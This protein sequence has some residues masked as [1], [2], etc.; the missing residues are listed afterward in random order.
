LI[1]FCDEWDPDCDPYIG[2]KGDEDERHNSNGYFV[3]FCDDHD[4]N[5]VIGWIGGEGKREGR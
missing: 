3:D 2:L 1:D 5:C 4:P